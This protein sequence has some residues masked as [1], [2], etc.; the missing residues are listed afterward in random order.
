MEEV[1]I[2]RRRAFEGW[3]VGGNREMRR[4]LLFT[5][6]RKGCMVEVKK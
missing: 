4:D 3:T 6:C 1:E 2:N 5:D